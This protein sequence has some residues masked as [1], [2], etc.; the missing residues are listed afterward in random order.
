MDQTDDQFSQRPHDQ[1]PINDTP[2]HIYE[3]DD[4]FLLQGQPEERRGSRLGDTRVR[5]ELPQHPTFRRVKQGV[6][7]ATKETYKPR[8]PM[9]QAISASKRVLIGVPLA[10]ME[11]EHERL[12]KFKALAVLSSDAISS[13]AYATEA[14]L[15]NLVAAGSAHLGLTLPISLVIIGLLGIVTISYRQSEPGNAARVG[16]CCR[17]HD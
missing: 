9:E 6:L 13:V 1:E 11:A 16:C 10:T 4:D 3:S 7:E 17:S 2:Q 8:T 12:T 14:I 15:I 5:I